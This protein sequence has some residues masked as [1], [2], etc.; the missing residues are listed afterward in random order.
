MN[1]RIRRIRTVVAVAAV[2]A[3]AFLVGRWT[4]GPSAP[5]PHP[6][7]ETPAKDAGA[8]TVWTCSMHPQIRRD[9]P[10]KCPI[11]FMDLVP[12]HDGAGAA[13][14]AGEREI[15]LTETARRLAR[16]RTEEVRTGYPDVR[17][18]MVGKVAFDE[19]RIKTVTPYVAGRIDRLYVD[20]T[21]LPIQQGDHVADL[22]SPQLIAAQSEY[23]EAMRAREALAGSELAIMRDTAAR[24]V[25]AAREKLRLWGLTPD[26]IGQLE[27]RGVPSEHVT[28]FA[29][30]SGVVVEKNVQEGMY[31]ETGTPLY[32]VADLG[33][34]WVELQAFESDLAWIHLGQEV[35]FTVDAYPGETFRGRISFVEP[36]VDPGTR[37]VD[38]RVRTVNDGLRLKP[39]MLVRASVRARIAGAGR[40]YDPYLAGKWIGPM[41]PWVI[42]D[43]PGRCDVCGMDLV[44]AERLGYVRAEPARDAPVIVPDTAP[45]LTGKRAVVYVERD[46]PEGPIYAGREVVLGPHAGDVYVV[47]SGLAVGERVVVEGAFAIDASLQIQAKPSMM[48]GASGVGASPAEPRAPGAG[49]VHGTAPVPAP[50]A[51]APAPAAAG[52]ALTALYRAYLELHAA[53]V[54][55]DADRA[56]AAFERVESAAGAAHAAGADVGA[57]HAAA[58][59]GRNETTLERQR[60]AFHD[61]SAA[62]AAEAR[63]DG[64]PIDDLRIMTCPMTPRGGS[65]WI[66]VGATVANPYFGEAMLRCGSEVDAPRRTGLDR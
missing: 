41:H 66:Q 63:A 55:D 32:R 16:V 53:L 31:V 12:V 29:P 59:A 49:H 19:T 27:A 11:C 54:A 9:R 20:Y 2:I 62:L 36:V 48:T 8:A 5:P 46:G 43:G 61:L 47:E 30:M 52:G 4:G 56:R 60:H 13:P 40:V 51:A 50:P 64:V 7:A 58:L 23:L 1:E 28:L 37:T 22:Y 15:A 45:L 38:L 42:K 18:S 26:Q 17:V 3:A 25:E 57:V 39:E 35:E 6:A 34:V 21:W 65:E 44:P 24:T 14:A 33:V 10:G